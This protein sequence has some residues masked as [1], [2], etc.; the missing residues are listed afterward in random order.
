MI[1]EEFFNKNTK[2]AKADKMNSAKK[3]L[4]RKVFDVMS[5]LKLHDDLS[6]DLGK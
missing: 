4:E 3:K 5:F 1:K 2:S 6:S